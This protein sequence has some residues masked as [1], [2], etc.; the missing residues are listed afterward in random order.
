M[1][2][3]AIEFKN[4]NSGDWVVSREDRR[5]M[6]KVISLLDALRLKQRKSR[7]GG[8]DVASAAEEA[9]LKTIQTFESWE[10]IK[11]TE[12]PFDIEAYGADL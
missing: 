6:K 11:E 10:L 12:L 1:E 4:K 7:Y 9:L 5:D 8:D 2:K 3:T